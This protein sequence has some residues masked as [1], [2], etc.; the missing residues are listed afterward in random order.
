VTRT[1]MWPTE[2]NRRA[3]EERF[4]HQG[5]ATDRIPDAIKER[6]PALD[7][8]HVLHMPCGTGEIDVELA[9]MGALVTGVDPDEEALAVARDSAP[10]AAFFQA[11]LD[12]L[13]LQFRRHRFSVVYAGEGTLASVNDLD[14]FVSACA[15]ALRKGGQLFLYDWHPVA[16]CI[17]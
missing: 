5:R 1:L 12:E 10:K 13:P 17:D 7:G 16:M 3:W 9:K 6:L 2:Q 14:R 8:K 11:S 4:A 15:A